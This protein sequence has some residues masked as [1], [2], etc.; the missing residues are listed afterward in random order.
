MS[1]LNQMLRDLEQRRGQTADAANPAISDLREPPA[2][3]RARARQWTLPV[4]I[5]LVVLLSLA[6]VW[7]LL[8]GTSEQPSAIQRTANLPVEPMAL[9][10]D[11]NE[12][13]VEAEVRQQPAL[14]APIAAP[15][16]TSLQPA[17]AVE[18]A[19]DRE[20]QESATAPAAREPQLLAQR[21]EPSESPTDQPETPPAPDS[22]VLQAAQVREQPVA[23]TEA[24]EHINQDQ[25]A[26]SHSNIQG[27]RRSDHDDPLASALSHWQAGRSEQAERLLARQLEQRPDW[28]QARLH[29]AQLMLQQQRSEE[30]IELL[31]A[32]LQLDPAALELRSLLARSL[33]G[34]GRIE[35]AIAT[36]EAAPVLNRSDALLL[37]AALYQ[38]QQRYTHAKQRYR[39]AVE[40]D[41]SQGRGWAGLAISL[42]ALGEPEQA[43]HAW[44]QAL[45]RSDLPAGL[46]G[47]ARERIDLLS[48]G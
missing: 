25:G 38:Q 41:A 31:Q 47:Y 15:S 24:D 29:Q 46:R 21:P 48:R 36:L 37:L 1:V 42:E 4:L 10:A 11:P 9:P 19:E 5:C 45:A 16:E 2:A 6:L 18:Q 34:S 39:Q 27:V 32:G 12:R 35:T 44:Q 28:H 7:A 26:P 14:P 33:Q 40:L 3:G 22:E 23:A 30:A 8:I 20:S 43:L 13:T 17:P